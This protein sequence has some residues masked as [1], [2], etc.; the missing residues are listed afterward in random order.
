MSLLIWEHHENYV[1]MLSDTLVTAGDG[2]TPVCYQSK[3]SALPGL[4]LAMATMG[5]A[6]IG[7]HLYR[8]LMQVDAGEDIEAVNGVAPELLRHIRD[9]LEEQRPDDG[10]STITLFG[11]P[12]GSEHVSVYS[13]TSR[14]GAEF[15]SKREELGKV[16]VKPGPQEFTLDYPETYEAKIDL[17]C[18]IRE[19][20]ERF[21]EEGKAFVRIGGELQ[22]T[23]V[24]NGRVDQAVWHR[25]PDYDQSLPSVRM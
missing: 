16:S 9:G 8:T 1:Q 20:Q 21:R 13:Y 18:R 15:E 17:A 22:A 6:E 5:T 14:D 11:F 25:F 23:H 19:E 4:N 24:S 3:V 2:V 7:L 12:N 10:I